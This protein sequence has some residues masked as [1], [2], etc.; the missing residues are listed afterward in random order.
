MPRS[1]IPI[2][3][4]VR[5]L[6]DAVALLVAGVLSVGVALVAVPA[7]AA[8]DVGVPP[9][10]QARRVAGGSESTSLY[11]RQKVTSTKHKTLVLTLSSYTYSEGT[12]LSIGLYRG[13]EQHYWTF[14]M[15]AKNLKINAKGSGSLSTKAATPYGSVSLRIKPQK[16]WKTNTCKGILVSKSRPVVLT[17]KFVFD[18]TSSWGTVGKAKFKFGTATVSRATGADGSACYASNACPKAGGNWSAYEGPVAFSGSWTKGDKTGW[19]YATRS[20]ALKKGAFRSDYIAAKVPLPQLTTDAGAATLAVTGR[21]PIKGSAKL[22]GDDS[23]TYDSHCKGGKTYSSTYWSN[24]S[25]TNGTKGLQVKMSAYGTL[26]ITDNDNGYIN[27][28][29]AAS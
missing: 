2:R 21:G 29:T 1:S 18:S 14:P 3:R 27:Q 5:G 22:S 13:H 26:K 19:M 4:Q 20:V 25:F 17:G 8:D 28:R 11:A 23:Y 7:T 6:A 10:V 16:K 24:A 9:S 12:H 15:P